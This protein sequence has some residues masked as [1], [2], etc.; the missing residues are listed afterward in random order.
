MP[1]DPRRAAA[2]E[3]A[4]RILT[5]ASEPSGDF[6]PWHEIEAEEEA[7]RQ[8]E[9]EAVAEEARQAEHHAECMSE[10][11]RQ[12]LDDKSWDFLG[13]WMDNSEWEIVIEMAA[14]VMIEH[15]VKVPDDV[16]G[17]IESSGWYWDWDETIVTALRA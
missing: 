4:I 14:S 9:R 17:F 8:A 1:A 3:L 2:R 13:Y 7:E 12:W 16:V 10:L 15:G 5:D 6:R 11:V